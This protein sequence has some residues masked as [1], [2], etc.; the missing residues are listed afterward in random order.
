MTGKA[1]RMTDLVNSSNLIQVL[2]LLNADEELTNEDLID[3]EA[4]EKEL[5][6]QFTLHGLFFKINAAMT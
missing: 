2:T 1:N 3:L 6:M 5:K 4:F